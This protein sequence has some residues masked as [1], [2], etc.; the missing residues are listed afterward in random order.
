MAAAAEALR[1]PTQTRLL[2]SCCSSGKA[3]MHALQL[4]SRVCG[5][6][7]G[8]VL[9]SRGLLQ[10]VEVRERTS[11]RAAGR[12]AGS[13]GMLGCLLVPLELLVR[14][15]CTG[16]SLPGCL[17]AALAML[18]CTVVSLLGRPLGMTGLGCGAES[19]PGGLP[20]ALGRLAMLGCGAWSLLTCLLCVGTCSSTGVG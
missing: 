6:A 11:G 3:T 14:L 2:L 4:T 10:Q 8:T 17:L 16:G 19:L 1:V 15:C 7:A 20:G 13:G 9:A 5:L 12:L 18:G